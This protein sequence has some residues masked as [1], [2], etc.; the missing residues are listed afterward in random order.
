MPEQEAAVIRLIT[1]SDDAGS[2]QGANKAIIRAAEHPFVKNISLMATG[3]YIE[4]AARELKDKKHICFGLHFT[5]N[6][7]WDLV[8]WGPVSPVSRVSSL[9]ERDGWFYPDPAASHKAG[10][11]IEEIYTEW[12]SQLD[13]LTKLGFDVRYADTHM[14]PELAFEGLA[15]IMSGWYKEKGLVDHRYFYN[16]LPHIDDISKTDGLFEDVIREISEGQYFYLTHPA[17]STEDMY[18]TGNKTAP[19]EEIVG[20]RQKDMEFVTSHK[21][22]EIC[23][24][25]NVQP[26]RYDEAVKSEADRDSGRAWLGV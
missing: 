7:E 11:L 24:K 16:P 1:R 14:F 3:A 22:I 23:E 20:G 13:R 18:L 19:T 6:A 2:S 21:T 17:Q 8:K 4:E 26:I 9:V 10:A 15:D 12:C 5:M 25:Y